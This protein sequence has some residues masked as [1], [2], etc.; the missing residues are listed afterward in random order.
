MGIDLVSD[1]GEFFGDFDVTA[2]WEGVAFQIHFENFYEP[3][4]TNL[5]TV[6]EASAPRAVCRAADVQ[7]IAHDDILVIPVDGVQTRYKVVGIQ[8]DGAGM[9]T[10][11]LLEA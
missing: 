5:G 8:P 1:F 10:L 4:E 2:T 11:I 3:M 7:G 6:V 9:T